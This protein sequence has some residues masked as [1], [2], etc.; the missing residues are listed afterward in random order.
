MGGEDHY[1]Y[2]PTNL[3]EPFMNSLP[4]PAPGP[5]GNP[6][7]FYSGSFP[8]IS[9]GCKEALARLQAGLA[10][11]CCQP[12]RESP[13][14]GLSSHSN[15]N[16]P[17]PSF[18]FQLPSFLSF[19]CPDGDLST[20]TDFPELS[21]VALAA[22]PLPPPVLSILFVQGPSIACDAPLRQLA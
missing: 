22:S 5:I 21:V 2:F 17:T 18:P 19:Q 9:P 10:S 7:V 8:S 15:A 4:P 3:A 16:C 1:F 6:S 11:P 20:S 12:R 13:L 14:T